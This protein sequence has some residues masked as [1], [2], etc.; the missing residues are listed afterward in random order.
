ML[1][2]DN[3]PE[4]Y[5]DGSWISEKTNSNVDGVSNIFTLKDPQSYDLLDNQASHTAKYMAF[6]VLKC[7]NSTSEVTCAD[8]G[9]N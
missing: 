9:E 3:N 7:Q 6:Q 4:F 2:E 8:F 5:V 1:S